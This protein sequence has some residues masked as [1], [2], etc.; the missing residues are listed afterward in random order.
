MILATSIDR[1]VR[2]T[3]PAAGNSDTERNSDV[4]ININTQAKRDA[5]NFS[6]SAPEPDSAS[7]ISLGTIRSL[8]LGT[9]EAIR[10]FPKKPESLVQIPTL[11]DPE[12][13]Q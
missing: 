12:G 7:A 1:M 11:R 6:N 2:S 3:P 10:E 9:R 8:S 4:N 13:K 5:S